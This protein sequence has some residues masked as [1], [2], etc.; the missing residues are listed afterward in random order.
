MDYIY[1]YY[2]YIY[3]IYIYYIYIYILYIYIYL[4]DIMSLYNI[5]HGISLEH[6]WNM[7]GHMR[8]H[9][10]SPI[11]ITFLNGSSMEHTEH[12]SI[13]GNCPSR[14]SVDPMDI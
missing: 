10:E 6:I 13:N 7:L 14:T 5:I 12:S 1:I 2:I 8:F 9:G 4:Y 3:Y 11:Q